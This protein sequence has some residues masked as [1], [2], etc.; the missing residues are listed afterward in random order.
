MVWNDFDGH[1]EMAQRN[2]RHSGL[3][4]QGDRT[5]LKALSSE[6]GT[7]VMGHEEGQ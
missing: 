4:G 5:R 6:Q 2:E 3:M 1:I 7:G